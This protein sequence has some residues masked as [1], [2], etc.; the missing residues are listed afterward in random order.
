MYSFKIHEKLCWIFKFTVMS[1]NVLCVIKLKHRVKFEA[2]IKFF[3][4]KN[5]I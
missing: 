4:V 5:V 1:V 3:L 2:K